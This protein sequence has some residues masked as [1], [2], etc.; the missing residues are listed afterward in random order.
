M[1]ILGYFLVGCVAL[2]AFRLALNI[3]IIL[4]FCLFGWSLLQNPK[5]TLALL[6]GGMGLTLLTTY[7]VMLCGAFAAFAG[8]GLAARRS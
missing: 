5:E 2:A 1:R 4:A 7:P 3:A 6:V 8:L